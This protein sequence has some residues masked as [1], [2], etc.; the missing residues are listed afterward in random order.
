MSD[1]TSSANLLGI[2]SSHGT[3]R[4]TDNTL[5]AVGSLDTPQQSSPIYKKKEEGWSAIIPD[6]FCS[7]KTTESLSPLVILGNMDRTD[8]SIWEYDFPTKSF[9]NKHHSFGSILI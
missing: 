9:G 3:N 7:T 1:S 5:R 6:G 2:Y 4:N 8:S